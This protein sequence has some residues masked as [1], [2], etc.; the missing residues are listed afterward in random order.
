[1]KFGRRPDSNN[2]GCGVT[3]QHVVCTLWVADD[4]DTASLASN[5]GKI[6]LKDPTKWC[7]GV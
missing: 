1:M 4:D 7:I 2:S 3:Q 5:S 6:T